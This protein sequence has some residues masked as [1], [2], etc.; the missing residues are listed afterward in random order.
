MNQNMQ[1]MKNKL[2]YI[3]IC[4]ALL[5]ILL[6]RD[7]TPDNELRYL[8][9][10][11]EAL[12]NGTFFTFTNHGIPYADKPPLYFWLIMFGKFL[13]GKHYMLFL[14]AISNIRWY[15]SME[16]ISFKKFCICTF[17]WGSCKSICKKSRYLLIETIY[18]LIVATFLLLLLI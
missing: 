1:L 14:S 4:L 11:D 15:S 10:A 3:G 9:I 8:S 12:R 5:P 6:F 18:L 7:Y 17:S 16:N 2:P 13:F